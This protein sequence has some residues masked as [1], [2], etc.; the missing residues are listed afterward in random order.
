MIAQLGHSVTLVRNVLPRDSSDP[1][2]LE[3]AHE[4]GYILLTCNRDDF[5]HLAQTM[6]HQG[7]MIVIRRRTRAEERAS[8]LRLLEPAG[9]A[10]IQNNICFA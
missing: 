9:E 4:H 1:S 8:L 3:F 2:L 6:P 7:I 5:L 10:G